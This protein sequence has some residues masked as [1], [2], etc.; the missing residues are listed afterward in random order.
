ML[1]PEIP[2]SSLSAIRPIVGVAGSRM[3]RQVR[4]VMSGGMSA[5]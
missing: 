5:S 3:R 1:N 4:S 2:P